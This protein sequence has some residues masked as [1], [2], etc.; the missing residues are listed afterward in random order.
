MAARAAFNPVYP[1]DYALLPDDYERD[2]Y[3]IV[4]REGAAPFNPVYPYHQP[5]AGDFGFPVI[6]PP[7]FNSYDFTS[8]HGNTL[9]LRLKKPL[10]RTSQGLSLLIGDGLGL[11]SEGRLFSTSMLPDAEPPLNI[12]GDQIHLR[13]GKGLFVDNEG[14]LQTVCDITASENPLVINNR[15]LELNIGPGLQVNSAGQLEALGTVQTTSLPLK[16]ENNNLELLIGKGLTLDEQGQLRLAPNLLWP[17]SPLAIEKGSNHLILFYNQSL[18]LQDGK[19]CLPEPFDPLVLDSGRLRLELAKDSGMFV[20]NAGSLGLKWGPGLQVE[21]GAVTLKT[22]REFALTTEGIH[23]TSPTSPL[24]VN[25]QGQLGL[26]LGYGFHAHRGVLEMTPN[27]IWTGIP[28]ANNGT[29]MK[30]HDCKIYL[31]LTR[32]GPMVHGVFMLQAP[33]YELT[34]NGMRDIVFAFG[35]TGALV[36]PAP[37]TWWGALDPPISNAAQAVRK[38]RAAPEPVENTPPPKRRGDLA[39]LSARVEEEKAQS[40]PPDHLNENWLDYM[41]LLRFMP[42]TELYP[43]AASIPTNLQYHDTRLNLRRATLQIRLNGDPN[44]HY[45]LAFKLDLVG[46]EKASMVTDTVSFWYLA[47]DY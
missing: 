2:E 24:E 1:Y 14:T 44:K 41:H 40:E 37:V 47:E 20:T 13:Y 27:T 10:K 28:I 8:I 11:D 33:D 31:S 4:A 43:R 21:D 18:D 6:M 30:A 35:D 29:Y 17:E 25:K 19:L 3:V 36:H 45:Q 38:K 46:S 7:F 12:E 39:A 9:S 16:V 32:V 26:S 22:S 5:V 23:L 42:S 15:V 34:T